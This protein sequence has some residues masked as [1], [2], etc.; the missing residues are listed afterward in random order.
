M[1]HKM[2]EWD[3]ITDL[4]C[5]VLLLCMLCCFLLFVRL[6]EVFLAPIEARSANL[7]E[8]GQKN[9]LVQQP[10]QILKI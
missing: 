2:D 4:Q 6:L 1:K 10:G 9:S 7:D 8:F 5:L 3:W